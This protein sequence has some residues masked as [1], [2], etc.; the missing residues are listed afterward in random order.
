MKHLTLALFLLAAACGGGDDGGD[1]DGIDVSGLTYAP[2]TDATHVGGFDVI[3][4]DGF[5]SVQG[6]VYNAVTPNRVRDTLG[7]NGACTW[8]KAPSLVC[9]PACP[10]GMTCGAGNVCV[11]SP[12]AQDVGTVTVAGL[13]ADV[14]MPPRPPVYYYNFTG[15]LPHPGFAAG[16]GMRLDAPGLS[17]LGWGID[18][19]VVPSTTMNVQSGAAVPVTWTAP[20]MTGPA[21]VEITLNVNGHGLVGSHVDCV[22]E[23][24]GSFTIP[25]PMVTSLLNDGLSGFPTLTVRRTTTDSAD[26]TNGCVELDVE[27]AVTIDVIIPGLESCD[28]DEDCTP[29][30]TC[31][32]DLTCG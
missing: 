17:L 26:T 30:E 14:S 3:L 23:D 21:K 20:T 5:T 29:P 24:T 31:Q 28:G 10:S 27:S 2:C 11:D 13:L 25:E 22:V 19:L 16:A 6:Q 18:P 7:T 9:N 32:A 12:V 15:T 4:G 8:L 1:D